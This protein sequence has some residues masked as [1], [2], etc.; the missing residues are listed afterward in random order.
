MVHDE[1]WAAAGMHEHD[2]W[3]CVDCLERRLGRQRTADDLQDVP[4]NNPGDAPDPPR[5]AVA[6]AEAALA[7]A[8]RRLDAQHSG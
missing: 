6:K 7:R 1:V 4:L 2:G 8:W 5:L 3:L